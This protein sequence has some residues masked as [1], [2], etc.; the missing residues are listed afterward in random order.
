MIPTNRRQEKFAALWSEQEELKGAR[1]THWKLANGFVAAKLESFRKIAL[2][3]FTKSFPEWRTMPRD[4][5]QKLF[6]GLHW[7]DLKTQQ[8]RFRDFSA[9]FVVFE[10]VELKNTAARGSTPSYELLPTG[11]DVKLAYELFSVSDRDFAKEVRRQIGKYRKGLELREAALK[12]QALADAKAKLKAAEK[13]ALEARE[14]LQ[15][16]EA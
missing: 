7:V 2:S 15:K 9:A 1:E 8:L 12:E 10:V 4:E 14:E 3:V 16:L 11:E 5:K 6:G 13:A